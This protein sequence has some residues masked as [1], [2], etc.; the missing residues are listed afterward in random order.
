MGDFGSDSTG[1]FTDLDGDL[2]VFLLPKPLI[3]LV[4]GELLPKVFVFDL[5]LKGDEASLFLPDLFG[6]ELVYEGLRDL[7]VGE[8]EAE[9]ELPL[10][11]ALVGEVAEV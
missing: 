2:E 5:E 6:L 3:G 11:V 7:L 4:F 10:F 9:I 8:V 1:V